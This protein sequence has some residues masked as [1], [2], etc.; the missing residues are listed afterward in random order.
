MSKVKKLLIRGNAAMLHFY[1]QFYS[2]LPLI[3]IGSFIGLVVLLNIVMQLK[4]SSLIK[5]SIKPGQCYSTEPGSLHATVLKVVQ[6]DASISELEEEPFVRYEAY[7]YR[8][9]T[10]GLAWRKTDLEPSEAVWQRESGWAFGARELLHE[11]FYATMQQ[12]PCSAYDAV[13]ALFELHEHAL[14]LEADLRLLLYREG[15]L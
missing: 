14:V 4:G 8:E 7:V 2:V 5:P 15:L 12:V 9:G 10:R 1:T 11:R 3:T 6:V 13:E